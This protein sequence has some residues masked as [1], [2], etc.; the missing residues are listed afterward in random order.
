MNTKRILYIPILLLFGFLFGISHAHAAVVQ[1]EVATSSF[2][3][4]VDNVATTTLS[5]PTTQGELIVVSAMSNLPNSGGGLFAAV[6][7]NKG[8]TYTELFDFLGSDHDEELEMWYLANAPAGVNAVSVSEVVPATG[9]VWVAHYTGV[10]TS[11]PLDQFASPT[12]PGSSTPWGSPTITTTQA[13]ELLVGDA[14]GEY[15]TANCDMSTSGNWIGDFEDGGGFDG[16]NGNA[17]MYSYQTVSTIQTDIQ[18]TGTDS[19]TCQHYA[20]I[21]AFKAAPIP[22]PS[23][24]LLS[25]SSNSTVSSTITIS[26]SSTSSIG[27][28]GVQFQI[29]GVNLGSEVTATSGPSIYSTTWNTASSADGTHVISAIAYDT[30]DNSSTATSSVIVH[31]AMLA[32]TTSTSLSFS[33]TSGSAAT[34]SQSVVIE[35]SGTPSST[36]SW[37]ATSTQSW[38][39]VSQTAGSLPGSAS[40][41]ILLVASPTGL[42][43]GTYD[44]AVTISDI[45]ASTS[46]SLPVI[47]TI[48]GAQSNPSTGPVVDVPAGY[49]VSDYWNSSTPTNTSVSTSENVVPP[50]SF[51]TSTI[52]TTIASLQSEIQSLLAEIPAPMTFHFTQPLSLW[53]QGTDVQALQEF[54]VQQDAG[55]AAEKLEAHG[56]T[57]VFGYLTYNALK[58]YQASVGLPATGYFGTMTMGKVNSL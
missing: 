17:G 58:E 42:S 9:L 44:T 11:S 35:N 6:G 13:K 28:Q 31:N 33:A 39:T 40:T 24:S 46:V 4:A 7:D 50:L 53:D 43:A 29:D 22:P 16:N 10:A 3:D 19:G 25:P 38:L 52:E 23:V 12:S 36:L 34:S 27:I 18:N 47:F 48:S 26:A 55:P 15:E 20:G 54:L 45:D 41:S 30:S 56:T 1:V 5:I 49:G 57:Q 2:Y 51:S 37:S 21:A 32:V 8:D 14:Y